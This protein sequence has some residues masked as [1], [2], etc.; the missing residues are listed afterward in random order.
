M[1]PRATADRKA[2]RISGRTALIGRPIPIYPE[3]ARSNMSALPERSGTFTALDDREQ[4]SARRTFVVPRITYGDYLGES[5][6]DASAAPGV[7]YRIRSGEAVRHP[8]RRG[9]GA[10]SSGD[11]SEIEADR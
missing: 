4:A 11:G 7:G 5:P 9:S 6:R 1:G 3:R 10:V 8:V 2:Y